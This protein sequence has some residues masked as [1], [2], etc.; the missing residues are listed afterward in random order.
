MKSDYQTL[1]NSWN[2]SQNYSISFPIHIK[3]QTRHKQTFKTPAH[4]STFIYFAIVNWTYPKI[5]FLNKFIKFNDTVSIVTDRQGR[6]RFDKYPNNSVQRFSIFSNVWKIAQ[7]HERSVYKLLSEHTHALF[8]WK[9]I[10]VCKTFKGS[11]G[12]WGL[13]SSTV[14]DRHSERFY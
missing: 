8:I 5:S 7:T 2:I 14:I 1:N 4:G 6:Q 3:E 11:K 9:Y 12:K 10:F 13:A